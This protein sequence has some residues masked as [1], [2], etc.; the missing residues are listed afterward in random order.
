MPEKFIWEQPHSGNSTWMFIEAVSGLGFKHPFW[1]DLKRED[2][3]PLSFDVC[4]TVNGYEVPFS[5]CLKLID[6]N[7]TKC[8]ESR[9][10]ELLKERASE[11]VGKLYDLQDHVNSKIAELFP[12][13]E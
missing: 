6:E 11:L 2:D 13:V 8:I 10:K 1:D 3:K 9:A 4:L 7:L 5:R 12:G